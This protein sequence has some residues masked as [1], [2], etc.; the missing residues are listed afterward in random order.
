MTCTLALGPNDD[1]ELITPSGRRLYIPVTEHS[2]QFLWQIL[3]NATSERA[4]PGHVGGYPTQAVIDAWFNSEAKA[5][6]DAEECEARAA[7]LRD[8]YGFDLDFEI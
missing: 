6:R 5:K 7:A 8:K 2:T 1:L 3:W 4:R